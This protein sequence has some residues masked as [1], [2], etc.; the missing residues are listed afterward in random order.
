M[1][2]TASILSKH[3]GTLEHKHALK[4]SYLFTMHEA[5]QTDSDLIKFPSLQNRPNFQLSR[6]SGC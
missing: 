1:C 4:I 6:L 2:K 3:K 5:E